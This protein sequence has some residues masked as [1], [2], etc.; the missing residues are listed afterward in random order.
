MPV[1][2]DA[3][4]GD[5]ADGEFFSLA[6]ELYDHQSVVT[7]NTGGLI[8]ATAVYGTGP[9]LHLVGETERWTI[10]AAFCQN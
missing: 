2:G 3:D 1:S 4:L 6:T 8:V 5:R 10:R 9:P 7:N